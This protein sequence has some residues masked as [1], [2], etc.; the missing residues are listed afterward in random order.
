MKL[1]TLATALTVIGSSLIATSPVKA[2]WQNSKPTWNDFYPKT[3]NKAI[4]YMVDLER[5]PNEPG[6]VNYVTISDNDYSLMP[7]ECKGT[8]CVYLTRHEG[9]NNVLS[10]AV[11]CLTNRGKNLSV[12]SHD[13]SD[14]YT[15]LQK[16]AAS[17]VCR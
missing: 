5:K 6:W 17:L 14:D 15:G 2:F 1:A 13:W 12:N 10:K 16:K 11:D 3:N 8:K 4:S 7:V 9:E